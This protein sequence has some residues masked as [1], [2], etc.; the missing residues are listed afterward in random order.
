MQKI[1]Q[2]KNPNSIFVQRFMSEN[3]ILIVQSTDFGKMKLTPEIV[4]NKQR[5]KSR[6][7]SH[8]RD[9]ARCLIH[10]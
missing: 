6:P 8:A 1:K 2:N 7:I 5:E 9:F 3:K 10:K 4:N